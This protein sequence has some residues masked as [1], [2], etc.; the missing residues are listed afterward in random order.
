MQIVSLASKKVLMCE[1][2]SSVLVFTEA[3]L[4]FMFFETLEDTNCTSFLGKLF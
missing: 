4:L 1:S 3:V 2:Y